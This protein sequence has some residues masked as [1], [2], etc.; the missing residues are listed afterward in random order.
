[1]EAAQDKVEAFL[2]ELAPIQRPDSKSKIVD[3]GH[4][5]G[6]DRPERLSLES[7]QQT[8]PLTRRAPLGPRRHPDRGSIAASQSRNGVANE[9]PKVAKRSS[10][11]RP[12]E[13]R[14]AIQSP[15][16]CDWRRATATVAKLISLNRELF[17]STDQDAGHILFGESRE[18]R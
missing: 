11:Q 16:P 8:R 3:L 17:P 6:S 5:L 9:G 15:E 4:C 7:S 14:R 1:M 10:R 12:C 13:S 2:K 18:T